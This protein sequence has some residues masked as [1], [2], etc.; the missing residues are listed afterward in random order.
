MTTIYLPPL[1]ITLMMNPSKIN[2]RK[3][4]L[5]VNNDDES[6]SYKQASTQ[7]FWVK[8]MD[9]ELQALQHNKTWIFVDA[10]PKS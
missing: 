4:A 3:F 2:Q 1:T 9:V 5:S 10:P 7:D 6:V 8:V